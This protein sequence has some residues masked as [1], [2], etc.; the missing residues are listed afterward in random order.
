[1]KKQMNTRMG[2]PK[3]KISKMPMAAEEKMDAAMM[4]GNKSA[5]KKDAKFH[6][7]FGKDEKKGEEKKGKGKKSPFPFKKK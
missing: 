6:A 3:G 2:M 7:K 5:A 4:T 1:M